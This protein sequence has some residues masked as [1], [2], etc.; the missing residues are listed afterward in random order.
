MEFPFNV[1]ALLPDEITM[2]QSKDVGVDTIRH[3][4]N[5]EGHVDYQLKKNLSKIVDDI[6]L[7]SSKAQKLRGAI[8]TS[9]KLKS[10]D[11]HLYI[12]KDADFKNGI[13][14]IIGIIRVGYKRLFLADIYGELHECQPLCILDFYVHESK[15]RCGYGSRLFNHIIK[16]E[17]IA[18][19]QL[20]I[21]R[22]SEKFISFLKK[23][24]L[25]DNPI[26]QMNKFVVFE[27][28]F[29]DLVAVGGVSNNRRRSAPG[30]RKMHF[31]VSE[32]RHS[33]S[34]SLASIKSRRA[35]GR[36]VSNELCKFQLVPPIN[37]SGQDMERSNEVNSSE[38]TSVLT[39]RP[40]HAAR[41]TDN[42]RLNSRNDSSL[43]NFSRHSN[44]ASAVSSTVKTE[45][46]QKRTMYS[47][48]TKT[49]SLL[50]PSPTDRKMTS[51]DNPFSPEVRKTVL[52]SNSNNTNYT[53]NNIL[54]EI[55]TN[56]K[57][58]GT[59]WNVFGVPPT[60]LSSNPYSRTQKRGF[61]S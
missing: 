60:S 27:S 5:Q 59:G 25:L 31:A 32:T 23:Y 45:T 30:Y 18:P 13:G 17:N 22:P 53:I 10:S 34:A 12:L 44:N 9:L 8:T 58:L 20:A 57:S 52:T 3:A 16:T 41:K 28:F 29:K 54:N 2:I 55:N 1:N 49:H 14:C 46:N 33:S 19:H 21:D 51:L 38:Q 37:R 43:R 7:A 11:H 4:Y 42:S 48:N 26:S 6:G 47:G 15:Q 36:A 56:K 39:S 50:Q 40:Y 35:S 61:P 24:Y